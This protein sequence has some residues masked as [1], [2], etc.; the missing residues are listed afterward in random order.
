M[1]EIIVVASFYGG[2]VI[3][4]CSQQTIFQKSGVL[5]G[6]IT[7]V[8][9]IGGVIGGAGGNTSLSELYSKQNVKISCIN[10]AAQ[11]CGGFM[12]I[13]FGKNQSILSISNCYTR[14]SVL[15][16]SVKTGGFI[17]NILFES[18]T[19]VIDFS[20]IYSSNDV[21]G[22]ANVGSAFG[23]IAGSFQGSISSNHFFYNSDKNS[24]LPNISDNPFSYSNIV[25]V[26]TPFIGFGSSVFFFWEYPNERNKGKTIYNI[27]F[28]EYL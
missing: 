5:S 7:G 1:S 9:G 17:G 3:G 12:G 11:S 21:E 26:L 18:N 2:G 16:N 28:I 4:Y 10:P 6:K 23:S 25:S 22:L 19:S 20:T 8:G 14:S 27:F 13:I 24:S 15:G